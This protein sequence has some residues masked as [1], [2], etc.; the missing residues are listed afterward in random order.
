MPRISPPALLAIEGGSP[1]RSARLPYARQTIEA[2]DVLAVSEALN[3]DFLTTG[4]RV[5]SFERAFAESVGAAHAVAVS[6]GTAALHAAAFAAG[7]DATSDAITTPLTFAATANCVRYLGGR[8]IFADVQRGSL[9]LDPSRVAEAWTPTTRAVITVD[10]AGLPSDLDELH[11]MCRARGAL[12][13]EDA[14]HALGATYRG[15]RVGQV[16]D[17]SVFSLHPAKHITAGEGGVVTT[18]DDGLAGAVRMFRTHGIASTPQQREREGSWHYDMSALGFNYRITD[19]QCALATTQLRKSGGWL[20]R[21]RELAAAYRDAFR[22]MPEL[23]LQSVLED[24]ESAWHLFVIL[25]KLD[26]LRVTRAQVFRALTAENIG[27]NVHY[28]PV[29]W[30]SY[31]QALGYR[32]GQWPVAEDAYERAISLPMFPGM[33]DDDVEDVVTAVRRVIANYTK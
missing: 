10:F 27:V 25:L 14:C 29:P 31:Y 3:S 28:I 21:R 24:R 33:S 22:D 32:K 18:N 5:S 8:V 23:E 13:I 26:R 6:S 7:I 15:R 16:A 2:D 4:P 19:I 1:V 20:G 12:L 9:N 30:H 17:L 11:A